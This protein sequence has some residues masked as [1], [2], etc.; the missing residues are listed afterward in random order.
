MLPI[1]RAGPTV[2]EFAVEP[3]PRELSLANNRALATVNG[4][5]D[6]LKVLLV[7]GRP[8]AGG[9]VWRNL[10]KSDPSVDLIHFTI[11]RP[12]H[13][14]DPTP[15]RELSLIPFPV[16]ELFEERL[17]EF[18]LVVFDRYIRRGVITDLYL[19]HVADYVRGGGALLDG[20]GPSFAEPLTTL[21][22]SALGEIYPGAP[23]RAGR[24]PPLPSGPDR[25]RPSPPGDG[26]AGRRLGGAALGA[27]A[28]AGR[29]RAAARPGLAVGRGGGG[30]CC[31]W[32]GWARAG[33]GSSPAIRCGSGRA[34]IR[35]A[36]RMASCCAG[37]RT[38]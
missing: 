33:S 30:R 29:G 6:R 20:T 9:R 36:G 7:S 5:R 35:A 26:A 24:Q 21:Y 3:G 17:A 31:W 28:P 4:V 14:Q 23:H 13:K 25:N 10:L 22:E 15:T 16:R 12:P 8:H 37:W 38:G 34:A 27:L 18:D 1:S 32:T 11:L 19:V 2:F